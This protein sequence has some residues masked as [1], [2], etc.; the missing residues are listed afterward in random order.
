MNTQQQARK[1]AIRHEGPAA[2]FFEGALLGNGRLGAVVTTRPDAVVIHFGHNNVWDI[3]IAENH[4]QEIG[5][6]K[7]VFERLRAIPE[8]HESLMDDDW[9]RAYVEMSSENYSLPYPRPMPCGSLLLGFDTRTTEVLGHTLDVADGQ[10]EI[11][12]LTEGRHSVLQLFVDQRGDRLWAAWRADAAD[13]SSAALAPFNRIKLLPDPLTPQELPAY[14]SACSADGRRL[15]FRQS[16]PRS[17]DGAGPQDRAFRLTAC[18]SA[19]TAVRGRPAADA[20]EARIAATGAFVVCAALEE[21]AAAEVP[22]T[23]AAEPETQGETKASDG[24]EGALE[25]GRPDEAAFARAREASDRVW[26]AYWSRSGVA[27]GDEFLEKIWYRN[28]YFFQ[29]AVSENAACPGLFANWS[30]GRIGSEWHGDYHMNYNTQQPF[31]V[32][33]SSNHA[34]K[35]LAYANMVDHVLPVSRQWAREYYGLRGAYFPHSAYPVEMSMMPYPVPHWGWEVCETPWT[36]Q[37]LWWHYLY[38]MERGFLADRAFVPMKDA[39]LFMVDYMKRPDARGEAWGDDRYHIFPTVVP[40]LYELTPGFRRNRDCIVDLT[41]TKFLFRAFGEACAALG[42]QAEES[43]LLAETREILR[44][45][46]DYPTAESRLGTVFV[47]VA[48]EDPEVVYNVPNGV[49]T[50]FPGEDHGLHSPPETYAVAE[51]SYRN[52]RNEGGNDL[53]FYP[54]AGARLGQLDLER[55]KRQIAYCML[56]NGTCTDKVL[57][58]G[59]RYSDTTAFDYMAPMGIWF[60]NFA[61]PAVLNECLIQSYTG[62]IRLFPNWPSDRD[63]SF[64]TLR[65]VGGFLVSASV[66]SGEAADVEIYSE[67][68]ERLRIYHPWGEGAV[69]WIRENGETLRMEGT[70]IEL[71]TAKGETVRLARA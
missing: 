41:L 47:S 34:D 38:T 44:A 36:V 25:S 8:R 15:S 10:C 19:E 14:A 20:L 71:E 61:L 65:A 52:H 32:A 57:Q 16:L 46:P 5:T 33:F 31:W 60:E 69:E 42:R 11:R 40:E 59:G 9:Y 17:L 30:Y 24:D 68:G 53:V 18:C 39:V 6:F 43:E 23:D 51:R 28:L 50:V 22:A 48:G 35:H 13:G 63:A 27:L 55:F 37:S 21:G 49:A 54:M 64:S 45:F 2:N 12:L 58:A 3:R 56:P 66:R 1:H 70:L 4:R 26:A 7:S 29:C 67:A 62:I